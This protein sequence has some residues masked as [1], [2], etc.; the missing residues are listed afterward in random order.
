MTKIKKPEEIFDEITKDFKTIFEDAL[1]SIVLYG[2]GAGSDFNPGTSDLNF[3]IIVSEEAI[4]SLDRAFETVSRW[5]KRNVATPLFMTQSYIQSS[6]DS[7]PLEFLNIK[8][9][10]I[11]VYGKD[12]L[13]DISIEGP[14]LRLQCEREI[15]GKLLLLREGFLET[16]GKQKRIKELIKASITAFISIFN[17]L[18][19]L[20]G[21]EIPPTRREIIQSVAKEI[22]INQEIFMKCLDIKQGKAEFSSSEV[23]DLF[24][25]YMV[26]ARKLWAVVDKMEI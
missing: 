2:S 11:L 13:K 23:K 7:Y 20:K 14:H 12:V 21:I 5:R 4:D 17:G 25:A 3:L 18:L 24:K 9:N 26:E 10:Y 6:L 22:P 8:K 16:E 1:V 19:Y 15:K